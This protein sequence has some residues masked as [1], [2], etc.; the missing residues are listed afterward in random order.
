M[1]TCQIISCRNNY[2][3][4]ESKI[5][6]F[7]RFPR[8]NALILQWEKACGRKHINIKNG[9]VCSIHFDS[10]AYKVYDLHNQ[11]K[12]RR[13]KSDAVPT[14][15]LGSSNG[16]VP[17]TA[18]NTTLNKEE[19]EVMNTTLFDEQMDV[20]NTT[21]FDEQMDV[22]NTTLFDE[23]MDVN[24]T[25]F[26]EQMK[27]STSRHLLNLNTPESSMS[28]ELPENFLDKSNNP[29]VEISKKGFVEFRLQN[30]ILKKQHVNDNNRKEYEIR[31]SEMERKR[32]NE[33]EKDKTSE[34]LFYEEDQDADSESEQKMNTKDRFKLESGKKIYECNQCGRIFFLQQMLVLHIQHFHLNRRYEYDNNCK[35]RFSSK[36]NLLK[37]KTIHL[38]KMLFSCSVCQIKFRLL[39]QLQCHK[40]IHMNEMHYACQHCSRRFVTVEECKKHEDSEHKKVKPFQ[41]NICGN[42]FVAKQG[43]QRHIA[44]K[45]EELFTCN[46]CTEAFH[47]KTL[48]NQH[49]FDTHIDDRFHTCKICL[50]TFLRLHHLTEHIKV[51]HSG[52]K[53]IE[54][55]SDAQSESQQ[56]T[57]CS[58]PPT[59]SPK[60]K[61]IFSISYRIPT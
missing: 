26:D 29:P 11:P 50:K 19:L 22:M 60:Y 35:K 54:N 5:I 55:Y 12:K 44:Q 40:K 49:L 25:L 57:V 46:Y 8:R 58:P 42:C 47:T 41:C 51:N 56:L 1:S 52:L 24:T 61:I 34:H 59:H 10:A 14:L 15:Y 48:L 23:Q 7:H 21:L 20:M 13:L 31:K 6:H 38:D 43:L 36:S 4:K 9:R 32:Q 53:K 39:E 45:H 37:H 30:N 16:E 33:E 3:T 28:G 27:A 2:R 18:M 17:D